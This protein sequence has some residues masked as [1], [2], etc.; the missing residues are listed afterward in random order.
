MEIPHKCHRTYF[1]SL[2]LFFEIL[3]QVHYFAFGPS[4]YAT[5]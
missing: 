1:Y 5:V 2:N 3:S 4:V